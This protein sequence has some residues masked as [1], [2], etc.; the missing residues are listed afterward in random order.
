MDVVDGVVCDAGEDLA[1]IE[2]QVEAV[3]LGGAEQGVDGGGSFPA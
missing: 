1:E 3:E 2:L